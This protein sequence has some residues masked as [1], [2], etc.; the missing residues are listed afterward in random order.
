VFSWLAKAYDWATGKID[1]TVASWVNTIVRGIWTFLHS[2]FSTVITAWNDFYNGVKALASGLGKLASE[3][4][5]WIKWLLDVFWR[6]FQDWL[7]K[8]VEAPLKVAY[9]WVVH[10][11]ATVWHYIT[12]PAD[13]VDLIWDNLIAKIES[14]AWDV[15]EKL[16]SFFLALII[17]NLDKF[18]TL[19]EDIINAVF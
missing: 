6:D 17:K 16:G 7:R 19:V 14:S 13:L 10:E 4:Y 3:V 2:L 11:G 5:D 18:V 1:S 9:D 8:Y 12:H 15:G